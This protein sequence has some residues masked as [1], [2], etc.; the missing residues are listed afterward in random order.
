MALQPLC[1]AF[2]SFFRLLIL[3]TIGR[4]P[5]KGDQPSATYSQHNTNRI[6][7]DIHASNGIPTNDTVFELVK[8]V[9]ALERTAAV[10][11]NLEL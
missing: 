1:W 4:N 2:A 8:T 5:S 7:A 6:N 11:G 10:G 3:Y 9:H